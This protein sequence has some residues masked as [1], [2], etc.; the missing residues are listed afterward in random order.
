MI[1][2][3]DPPGDNVPLAGL[4]LTPDKLLLADQSILP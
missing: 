2:S 4:K 3:I 1:T